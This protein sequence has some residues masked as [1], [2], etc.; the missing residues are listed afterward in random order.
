MEGVSRTSQNEVGAKGFSESAKYGCL[1]KGDHLR[2]GRG[3]VQV[4]QTYFLENMGVCGMA[5]I[6]KKGALGE[7]VHV[8]VGRGGLVCSFC[9]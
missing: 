6:G 9:C 2:W 4:A 8:H 7:G 3:A 1:Y 5:L